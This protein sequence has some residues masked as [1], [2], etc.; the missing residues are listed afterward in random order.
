MSLDRKMNMQMWYICTMEYL[1][2]LC[3]LQ[4]RMELEKNPPME[5]NPTKNTNI[6]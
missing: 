4:A 6:T 1:S 5:G 3:N 2:I